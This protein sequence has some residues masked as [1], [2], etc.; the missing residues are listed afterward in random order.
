MKNR[1][2]YTTRETKKV[3]LGWGGSSLRSFSLR[4][5]DESV[6]VLYSK[7]LYCKFF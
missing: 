6:P 3:V 7:V 1:K 5:M 4:F 2:A